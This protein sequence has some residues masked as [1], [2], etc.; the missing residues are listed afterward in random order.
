MT[1]LIDTNAFSELLRGNK[2]IL[3]YLDKS[4]SVIMTI[5]VVA[6]LLAGFKVGSKEKENKII[7]QDL[8]SHPKVIVANASLKTAS[9]FSEI[10][11][12]LKLNGK[13]IP[14]NDIWIAA[15]ALEFEA[16]LVTF[17]KHFKEIPNINLWDKLL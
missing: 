12:Y 2:F 6:E 1:V 3:E 10:K 7:L 13:P 5:I 16:T 4:D 8:L 17:D 11:H 14:I 9:I 15:H